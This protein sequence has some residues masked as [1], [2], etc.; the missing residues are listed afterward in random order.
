MEKPD[1]LIEDRRG[2]EA[3]DINDI[4]VLVKAPIDRVSQALFEVRQAINLRRNIYN[5]EVEITDLCFIVYQ[6]KKHPWT[7]IKIENC[8]LSERYLNCQDAQKLSKMLQTKAIFYSVI[9]NP[10]NIYYHLYIHGNSIEKFNF[11]Y[12]YEDADE[13]LD[14]SDEDELDTQGIYKFESK[15]RQ[16]KNSD[17]EDE[18]IFIDAFFKEHDAYV[19]PLDTVCESGKTGRKVT[20][21]IGGFQHKDLERM[22]YI[23]VK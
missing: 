13:E 19:P 6:L 14:I 21:K 17:I 18:F 8:E 23:S 9:D 20:L 11:C 5:Y 10:I 3:L 1:I 12:E 22:D 2:I 4:Q 16:I 7:L 15:L